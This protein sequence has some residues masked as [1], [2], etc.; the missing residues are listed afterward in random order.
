MYSMDMNSLLTKIRCIGGFLILLNL[1][2]GVSAEGVDPTPTPPPFRGPCVK[3]IE[4]DIACLSAV[5]DITNTLDFIVCTP[6]VGNP[7]TNCEAVSPQPILTCHIPQGA[8][9]APACPFPSEILTGLLV[10]CLNNEGSGNLSAYPLATPGRVRIEANFN[11]DLCVGSSMFKVDS[12]LALP[13]S[14]LCPL[15][16]LW[17]GIPGNERGKASGGISLSVHPSECEPCPPCIQTSTLTISCTGDLRFPGCI[18]TLLALP[19][20]IKG[21]PQCAPVSSEGALAT[22]TVDLSQLLPPFDDKSASNPCF[23]L[24]DNLVET[25]AGC[26]GENMAGLVCTATAPEGR[27][28]VRSSIP[29]AWSVCHDEIAS[30]YNG[31]GLPLSETCSVVN[32]CDGTPGNESGEFNSWHTGLALSAQQGPCEEEQVSPTPTQTRTASQTPTPS[33]PQNPTSTPTPTASQSPSVTATQPGAPTATP[34]PSLTQTLIA[35]RTPT[36]SP[37]GTPFGCDSGY[38]LLDSL[39]A[40]HRAG[41]PRL[42]DGSLFFGSDLARDMELVQLQNQPDSPSGGLDLV[43]LD[44]MGGV[45]FVAHPIVIQQDFFFPI[46]TEVAPRGRAVDIEM[47]Q[48]GTG[49]W[50]LTDF[51][52]IYRGGSTKAPNQA[53]LVP[54]TDQQGLWG[55]DIPLGSIRDPRMANPGGASLRAV[56]LVV[57]DIDGDNLAEGY[58]VIDSMGGRLMYNPNGSL[59]GSLQYAAEPV[60]SPLRLLNPF[61]YVWPFFPGLDIARDCELH[62]SKKGV[63]ILD[64]WG[65]IHPVPVDQPSN[66]VFFTTNRNPQAPDTLLTTVGLPYITIGFDDPATATDEGNPTLVGA[67][68]ASIFN[69]FEFCRG[70]QLGCYVMDRFGSVFALGASRATPDMLQPPFANAPMFF[71]SPIAEDL[72]TLSRD[73]GELPD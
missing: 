38:Y 55:F 73:Q 49:F 2:P 30:C 36:E 46:D 1:A 65:G 67:D 59:V 72:E 15:V 22:C 35:S 47:T 63:V 10:E 70:G 62:L 42:I 5:Q 7:A 51:G 39:G 68:V 26:L 23:A 40:R 48:D 17:D 33:Q 56:S 4:L 27:L 9:Q 61:G 45:H 8:L 66:P 12:P 24:Q 50:V 21:K 25:L 57:I 32:I 20:D 43:V 52:G 13:L 14:P 69:D 60:N 3:A 6:F 11:F 64:G 37:S 71:P 58:L 31:F 29:L 41:H 34:S 54:G 53:A 19:L 28:I 18:L 16:N 44:A